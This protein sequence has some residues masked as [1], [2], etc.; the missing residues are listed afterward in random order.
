MKSLSASSRLPAMVLAALVLLGAG[1]PAFAGFDEALRLYQAQEYDQALATFGQAAAEGDS[2]AQY[3]LAEML[4]M[5]EG[6][7][8]DMERAA[9]WYRAAAEQGHPA[10]Q[11]A[12]GT[13]YAIGQ[14]IEQNDVQAYV[15]FSLSTMRGNPVAEQNLLRA[16][17]LIGAT[18]R[19][20]ADQIVQ[21][22]APMYV[23]PFQPQNPGTGDQPGSPAP[24]Q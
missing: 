2:R 4:R 18:N 24:G 21:Q 17:Q 16:K 9:Q 20:F 1:T 11:N 15:W 14:G 22:Y 13:L 12:L 19:K 10:A 23:F 6:V 7:D 3:M 8:V 5:G